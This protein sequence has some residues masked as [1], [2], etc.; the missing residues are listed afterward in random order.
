M[1]SVRHSLQSAAL[2][3]VMFLV[4]LAPSS[5]A[6]ISV[7]E[8]H[9]YAYLANLVAL[10]RGLPVSDWGYPFSVTTE[11]LPFAHDLEIAREN[12]ARRSIVYE[13]DGCLRVECDLF[14]D[15]MSILDSLAQCVRR[16][17]WLSDALVCALNLPRGAIRDAINN[18][19][20]V[21]VSLRNRRA[22]ALL[23]DTDVDVMYSEFALINDVLGSN[24]RDPLQPIMVW[25]SARIILAE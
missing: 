11:G 1:T 18:T 3:D 12:L 22:S 8:L 2:T 13:E 10:N 5:I 9:L 17:D 4:G 6:P 21:A 16:K 20:G 24:S 19:P 23:K 25:L 14:L 7:A 15:E